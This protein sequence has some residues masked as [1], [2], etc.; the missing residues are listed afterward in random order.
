MKRYLTVDEVIYIHKELINEFG[1]S[2]GMRD[3]NSLEAAVM[4]PQVGYYKSIHDEAA[5]LMESLA[6]NHSF[7]DGNKRISFFATDVF[8][9]MNGYFISCESEEAN[10]FFIE[11]LESKSFRFEVIKTWLKQ[12]IKRLKQ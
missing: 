8:L 1:G 2:D 12:K 7:V 11:N 3:R 9:R 6:M 10:Q 5:A 4:R